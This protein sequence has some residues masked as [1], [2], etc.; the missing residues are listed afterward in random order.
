MSDLYTLKAEQRDDQGKGA[1]RRLRRLQGLV[2]AIVYGGNSAPANVSIQ[3]K[4]LTKALENEAFY[5][6]IITLELAGSQQQVILK[7]LQRHPSKPFIVHADFQRVSA[8]T[9]IKAHV[10]LHFIN[11]DNCV[12][13]KQQG[14]K[15]HHNFT[16]VDIVC[17][18]G[19]LPE[20]IEV[21]VAEMQ[22]GDILHLNELTLPKGVRLQAE[23]QG[24]DLETPVVAVE[25]AKGGEAEES[26]E[27]GESA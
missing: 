7:D 11:E 23:V 1:S 9:K 8:D 15:V 20:F 24:G 21:D 27:G 6:H 22:A 16:E 5:S 12:G 25:A 14:G 17:N 13:V 18:A 10:P 26:E 3:H 19:D 2:P 4:D